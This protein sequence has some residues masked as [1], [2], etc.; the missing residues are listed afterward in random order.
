MVYSGARQGFPTIAMEMEIAKGIAFLKRKNIKEVILMITS[1][2]RHSYIHM[3]VCV[4]NRRLMYLNHLSVK[5]LV[6]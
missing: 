1:N 5:M 3:C 4:L 2:N 6:W